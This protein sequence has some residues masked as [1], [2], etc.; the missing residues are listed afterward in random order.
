MAGLSLLAGDKL[1]LSTCSLLQEG[2]FCLNFK[3][4][5][6]TLAGQTASSG[7]VSQCHSVAERSPPYSDV[8]DA[9][10]ECGCKSLACACV[11][12]VSAIEPG[13]PA[14]APVLGVLTLGST[15]P[16][17]G[18]QLGLLQDL[19]RQLTPH[20]MEHTLPTVQ[21]LT[22]AFFGPFPEDVTARGRAPA[23]HKATAAAACRSDEPKG[24]D[25]A[26][27]G[28]A[29]VVTDAPASPWAAESADRHWADSAEPPKGSTRR[30]V[31]PSAADADSLLRF[32]DARVEARFCR[33]HAQQ[34]DWL[35]SM[36]G[37][38]TLIMLAMCFMPPVRLARH[39]SLGEALPGLVCILVILAK[40]A[41]PK[42]WYLRRRELLVTVAYL[43]T[44]LWSLH[45]LF[46][47]DFLRSLPVGLMARTPVQAF[48]GGPITMLTISIGF[49]PR[50][51]TLLPCHVLA[52]AICCARLP[53]LCTLCFPD[54]PQAC[55]AK[56]VA[57]LVGAGCASSAL[58]HY[59][60]CNSRKLF[61]AHAQ[62][63]EA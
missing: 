4:R 47:A 1:L 22:S 6:T 41:M 27:G 57:M 58:C 11:P 49:M 61:C 37:G 42:A 31:Q 23:K 14:V 56:Q 2:Y 32:C 28:L 45:V 7:L 18:R 5:H 13:E 8:E 34:C 60:E 19:A 40:L 46:K 54:A 24:P 38:L 36:W 35:D 20:L 25:D 21:Y 43:G 55:L 29:N 15:E 52:L 53:L 9:A 44:C 17:T 51:A 26:A 59:V 30:D 3:W 33:W 39:L 10:S 50:F 48:V 62:A 12:G 63:A 16:L